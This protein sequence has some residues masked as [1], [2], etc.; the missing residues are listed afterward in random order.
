MDSKWTFEYRKGQN[1]ERPEAD[2]N[3]NNVNEW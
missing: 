2:T 3:M 1:M